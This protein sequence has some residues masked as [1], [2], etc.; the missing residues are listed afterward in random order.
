MYDNK[1]FIQNLFDRNEIITKKN[2]LSKNDIIKLNNIN[3]KYNDSINNMINS[4][5]NVIEKYTNPHK[6]KYKIITD[7]LFKKFIKSYLE[8]NDDINIDTFNMCLSKYIFSDEYHNC[9]VNKIK[10]DIFECISKYYFLQKNF[11]TYLLNEVP[12]NIRTKLN[13]G[14]KDKGIDLI[15]KDNDNNWI[16]VQCKWRA[17]TNNCIDKNMIAGFIEELNRTKLDR[18]LVFTNVQQITKYFSENN[19][20]WIIEPSLKKIV[21]KSFIKFIL[22][23]E[24]EQIIN[25]IL[26]IKKLRNYQIEALNALSKSTDKNKQCIMFCG[27]GKSIV[28]IEYIKKV[29]VDK[30]VVLMPSLQLISQF[31][32]NLSI[33]Y[34]N[35][36]ILCIC[37]QLDSN[38]LT[39]G[40]ATAEQNKAIF[41]DFINHDVDNLFTTNSSIIHKKLTDDKI[42][43]LCTYQS[44][45][46][47]KSH[48][49]DLVD[50]TDDLIFSIRSYLKSCGF[51]IKVDEVFDENLNINLYR[52]R[53]D[54]YCQITEKPPIFLNFSEDPWHILDYRL[55]LNRKFDFNIRTPISTFRA[56]FINKQK[57]IFIVSFDFA[58]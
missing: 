29:N 16:G 39:C 53:N 50:S 25:P 21:T 15:Y 43:V 24:K 18:G 22:H 1:E 12:I 52:D 37:S 28:M 54:Y 23:F 2:I 49:F 42:I 32:K 30:A 9:N 45:F 46:L 47:L 11:E 8:N 48:K 14:T 58:K 26:P 7:V 56:F 55:I 38:S 17:K 4:S 51:T 35:Q 44:S 33:N 5:F 3:Q 27:T 40:E 41:N 31:Y 13:L 19:L 20:K 6:H 34:P 36:N 57:S 10:G